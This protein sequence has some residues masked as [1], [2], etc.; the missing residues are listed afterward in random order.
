MRY[1]VSNKGANIVAFLLAAGWNSTMDLI[2]QLKSRWG[3]V[4]FVDLTEFE[5]RAELMLVSKL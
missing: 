2:G 3:Q 1:R 5:F 4:V